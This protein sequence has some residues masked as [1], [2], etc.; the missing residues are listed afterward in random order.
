M[1]VL[2][3]WDGASG[4]PGMT[5]KNRR[6]TRDWRAG[7]VIVSS[8]GARARRRIDG[9]CQRDRDKVLRRRPRDCTKGSA[10]TDKTRLGAELT[11]AEVR[12]QLAVLLAEKEITSAL[13]RYCQAVDRRDWDQMRTVYHDDAYDDHGQLAG[14]VDDLIAAVRR[15]HETVLSSLHVLSNVSVDLADDLRSARVE[16]YC[17]SLQ[18][19]DP[20]VPDP[21]GDPEGKSTWTTIAC[22]YV[23]DFEY[24]DGPGW[25]IASRVLVMEWSRRE[26]DDDYLPAQ[27]SWNLPARD[28]TDPLYAPCRG[29][30]S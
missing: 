11:D 14:S 7:L 1:I 3:E 22:R 2:Q 15:R 13:T 4:D 5:N 27:P 29:G 21:F 23:D 24:R 30:L 10:M 12:R 6:R 26:N 18:H 28:G 17:M 9:D 8:Q 19:I 16:S 20:S 25:R